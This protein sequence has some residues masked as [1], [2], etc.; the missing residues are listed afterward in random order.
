MILLMAPNH[1]TSGL[2]RAADHLIN[3]HHTNNLSADDEWHCSI[4]LFREQNGVLV[5][6]L[7][8]E[9]SSAETGFLVCID[10]VHA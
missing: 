7:Y 5:A 1:P 3:P 10:N 8:S 9:G 4:H 2:I 6:Y